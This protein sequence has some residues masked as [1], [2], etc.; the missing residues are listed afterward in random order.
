VSLAPESFLAVARIVGAHGIKGEVRA[1]IITD[2][3][4]RLKQTPRLYRGEG[5]VPVDLERARLEKHGA[6]L[7]LAGVG[8]RDEAESLRGQILY[9]P[10][11][12]AVALPGDSYFWH[13]IIGLSVR[14]DD[15]DELGEVADIMQTGSNDVYVVRSDSRELL[16]PAIKDVVQDIDLAAGVIT[17]HLME[18][19]V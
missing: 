16:L 11:A 8:T 13:Q 9:V 2:F 12:E 18:G 7:K 17:V 5:H 6:I 1:E 10:E 19:L 15:G 14:S 3:P 4:E